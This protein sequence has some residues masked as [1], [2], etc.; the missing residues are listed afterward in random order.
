MP[1]TCGTWHVVCALGLSPQSQ[2][3]QATY[4]PTSYRHANRSPSLYDVIW[5]PWSF[6]GRWKA[7]ARRDLKLMIGFLR[8]NEVPAKRQQTR[9]RIHCGLFSYYIQCGKHCRLPMIIFNLLL[10]SLSKLRM[11]EPAS[12]S[13][14]NTTA[15]DCRQ[16]KRPYC[17]IIKKSR[18]INF[19]RELK[20]GTTDE[21]V[22]KWE[23]E[24]GRTGDL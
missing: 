11:L 19:G 16:Y 17:T 22:R 24:A 7:C 13:L 14:Y 21:A 12:Q 9:V 1:G 6:V 4:C 5:D 18:A 23:Q 15:V 20:H 2:A 3:K 8:Q 10:I